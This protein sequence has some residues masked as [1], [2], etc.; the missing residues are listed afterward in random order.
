MYH[1]SH[2][3]KIVA[4]ALLCAATIDASAQQ[5]RARTPGR[6][7][8]DEPVRFLQ[9]NI[10]EKD[11]RLDPASLVEQVAD[12]PANTFLFNMGGIVAQYPTQ[13]PFHYVSKFMPPG[14]DL[15][16]EVVQEAHARRT[17]ECGG[18]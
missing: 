13:V 2:M 16:G 15:F 12:F 8:M 3:K 7:W 18:Q 4:A 11:S 9:T 14:R 17:G 1:L 5:A 10:S 6:W